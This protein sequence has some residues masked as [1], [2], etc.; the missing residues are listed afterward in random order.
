MKILGSFQELIQTQIAS[1]LKRLTQVKS[2]VP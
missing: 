1:G 2:A